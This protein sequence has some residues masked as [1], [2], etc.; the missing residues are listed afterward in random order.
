MM[1]HIL[2]KNLVMKTYL[3]PFIMFRL[4]K[5]SSCQLMAKECALRTG[6]LPPRVLPSNSV[7]RYLTDFHIMIS[8][9]ILQSLKNREIDRVHNYGLYIA[10]VSTKHKAVDR[11]KTALR[12]WSN[13]M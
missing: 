3:P 2:M 5:Q 9:F 8:L 10:T 6:K 12:F 7:A 11:I 13:A 4:L 1:Q